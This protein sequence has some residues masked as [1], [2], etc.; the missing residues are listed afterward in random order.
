MS[1]CSAQVGL[2]HGVN[3]NAFMVNRISLIDVMCG[4]FYISVEQM[5]H[6]Y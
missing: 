4:H 2:I 6:S 1:S 5:L 3:P